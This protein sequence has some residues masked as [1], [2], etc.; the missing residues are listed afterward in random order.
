MQQVNKHPI[1]IPAC[2]LANPLS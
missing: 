1:L 2:I